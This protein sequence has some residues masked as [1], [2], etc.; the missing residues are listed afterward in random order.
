MYLSDWFHERGR[1]GRGGKGGER[2]RRE[3]DVDYL[4]TAPLLSKSLIKFLQV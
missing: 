3:R 2:K 1:E 4:M